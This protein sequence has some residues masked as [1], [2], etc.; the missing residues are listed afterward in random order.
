MIL[1]LFIQGKLEWKDFNIMEEANG[2]GKPVT[3]QI[4]VAVTDN[5]LEIRMYWAGKGTTLIP[6]K[7]TYG[8]LIS[9]IS[10]CQS[11]LFIS[12]PFL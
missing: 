9:A 11:M 2:T 6:K 1:N 10:A 8:P 7:G 12:D 4:N 3:K 5:M